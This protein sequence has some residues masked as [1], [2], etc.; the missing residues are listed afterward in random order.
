MKSDTSQLLQVA[1]VVCA[2]SL[3]LGACTTPNSEAPASQA[4]VPADVATGSNLPRRDRKN[5]V[6]EVNPDSVADSIRGST[7]NAGK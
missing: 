3:A 7:R 4:G 1:C 6:I 5:G 2:L